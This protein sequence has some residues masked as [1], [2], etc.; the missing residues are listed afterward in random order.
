MLAGERRS[1]SVRTA[2]DSTLVRIPR[3][4]LLPLMSANVRLSKDVWNTFAERRFESLV[5]GVERYMQLSRQAR[6]SWLQ[7]GEHRELEPQQVLMVEPGTHL[8]VLSGEVE[9]A[10]PEPQVAAQGALLLEV[11]HPLRV[12][13]LE[14]ARVVL[15]PR[16]AALPRA[17]VL[18]N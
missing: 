1:A 14:H 11:E 15:L 17:P 18:I 8:L 3:E 5:R 7:Q 10:H 6:R 16:R 9:F 12:V 2:K 13:A 4:A